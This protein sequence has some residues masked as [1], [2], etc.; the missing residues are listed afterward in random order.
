MNLAMAANHLAMLGRAPG[1]ETVAIG[2]WQPRAR[3]SAFDSTNPSH[4][5]GTV[6]NEVANAFRGSP[7]R[8]VLGG[9]TG[10]RTE[11]R[12]G[13]QP[14]S[15]ACCC[16]GQDKNKTIKKKKTEKRALLWLCRSIVGQASSGF[17]LADRGPGWVLGSVAGKQATSRE[18]EASLSLVSEDTKASQCA[19]GQQLRYSSGHP[20][21][22][23]RH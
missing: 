9:E 23:A 5:P 13:L 6:G 10:A 21:G 19:K 16:Y 3:P 11:P 18:D 17:L 20:Q 1:A 7:R 4:V 12:R 8:V 22:S 15:H 14:L 2:H